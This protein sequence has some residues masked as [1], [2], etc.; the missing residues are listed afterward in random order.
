MS[1]NILLEGFDWF[2]GANL[3]LNSD[4][5]QDTKI[6]GLQY[7]TSSLEDLPGKLL[8]SKDT[9]L[10]FSI[11]LVQSMSTKS[12][13]VSTTFKSLCLRGKKTFQQYTLVA[14]I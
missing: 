13:A 9:H 3:T 7:S 14:R 10:V 4:V 1:K 12:K 8:I 11:Y 2:H 5:D 6:F